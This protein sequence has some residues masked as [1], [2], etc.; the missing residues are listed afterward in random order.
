MFSGWRKLYV[1]ANTRNTFFPN[2]SECFP[3]FGIFFNKFIN[4]LEGFES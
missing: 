2:L 1:Y 4:F 3:A